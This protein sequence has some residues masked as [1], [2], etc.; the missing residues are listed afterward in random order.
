MPM[1]GKIRILAIAMVI[2][3]VVQSCEYHDVNDDVSS[4]PQTEEQL[5]EEINQTG[6]E[7]FRSAQILNPAST[8]PHG[9]FKLRF[10]QI[11]W[12]ALDEQEK[13]P[14]GKTFPEGSV[15]VKEV[16]SNNAVSVYAIMKKT[17][18]DYNAKEGW[19]W[20]EILPDGKPAY[21]LSLKGAVCVNCHRD[22]PNRDLVR[23]FDVH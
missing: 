16:F 7:Y 10:N 11:A 6:Y 21:Q 23:T 19:L 4:R 2:F 17:S 13:L 15:I 20:A 9:A 18:S 12:A 14:K 22:T 5:L 8:S 3:I 1:N